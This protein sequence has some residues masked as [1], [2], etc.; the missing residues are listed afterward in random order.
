MK[1]FNKTTLALA[2][3][4]FGALT[5][6]SAIAMSSV[7]HKEQLIEILADDTKKCSSVRQ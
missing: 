4:V 1:N 7:E 6:M 5:S 2:F 3:S